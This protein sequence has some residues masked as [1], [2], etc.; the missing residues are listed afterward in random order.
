MELKNYIQK[1]K[2]N[3]VDRYGTKKEVSPRANRK[4]HVS[5]KNENNRKQRARHTWNSASAKSV[6]LVAL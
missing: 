1:R 3:A 4:K 6:K 2:L 5:G